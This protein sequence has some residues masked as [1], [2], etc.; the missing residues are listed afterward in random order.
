MAG[1][2][3]PAKSP[4]ELAADLANAEA[5]SAMANAVTSVTDVLAKEQ[6]SVADSIQNAASIAAASPIADEITPEEIGPLME[7]DVV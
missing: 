6:A 7:G 1:M 2:A 3:P 5:L 4:E